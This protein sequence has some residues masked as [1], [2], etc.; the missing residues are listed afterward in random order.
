MVLCVPHTV[1]FG[2]R[3]AAWCRLFT[4]RAARVFFLRFC[5]V[6]R[7][8]R[9]M[10]L[11]SGIFGFR[12]RRSSCMLCFRSSAKRTNSNLQA[13]SSNRKF[14]FNSITQFYAEHCFGNPGGPGNDLRGDRCLVIG[15]LFPCTVFRKRRLFRQFLT[16]EDGGHPSA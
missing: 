2:V 9:D 13:V 14:G 7:V 3:F 8:R 5:R 1:R 10:R 4:E 16:G 11:S 15:S 6:V 12:G